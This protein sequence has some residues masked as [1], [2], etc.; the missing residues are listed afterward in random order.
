M[1]FGYSFYSK[2]LTQYMSEDIKSQQK[3][4]DYLESQFGQ[5]SMYLIAHEILEC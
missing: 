2:L 1:S 3:R 4:R 5:S